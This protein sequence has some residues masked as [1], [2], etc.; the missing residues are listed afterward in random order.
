MYPAFFELY[1]LNR[2]FFY[3]MYIRNMISEHK[4]Q[5]GN[6]KNPFPMQVKGLYTK[7]NNR[8]ER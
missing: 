8:I 2:Y 1:P 6:V 3:M 7:E 4:E 5:S